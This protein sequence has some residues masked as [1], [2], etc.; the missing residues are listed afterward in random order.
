MLSILPILEGPEQNVSYD[1]HNQVY[2][3]SRFR[4]KIMYKT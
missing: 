4:M 2:A 1:F 3:S